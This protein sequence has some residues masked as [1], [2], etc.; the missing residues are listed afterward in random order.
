MCISNVLSFWICRYKNEFVFQHHVVVKTTDE[1]RSLLTLS[2][3]T[4]VVVDNSKN[5]VR[6]TVLMTMTTSN[7]RKDNGDIIDQV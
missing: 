6:E 7:N 2:T 1:T 4:N 5:D 3:K